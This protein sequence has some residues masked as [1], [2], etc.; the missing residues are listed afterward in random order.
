MEV[1]GIDNTRKTKPIQMIEERRGN[2]VD[3]LLT[4]PTLT[5]RQFLQ[6]EMRPWE[7]MESSTSLSIV[8][9]YT[10]CW[11]LPFRY[12]I[13][14]MPQGA[15]Q[16]RESPVHYHQDISTATACPYHPSA[17]S[18]LR[19]GGSTCLF[20]KTW[21]FNVC[22]CVYC[23]TLTHLFRLNTPPTPSPHPQATPTPSPVI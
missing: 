23:N 22:D 6:N 2:A 13:I 12:P 19:V 1:E 20:P 11:R 5:L 18:T 8:I 17:T 3:I 14:V 7:A 15:R 4:T 10:L 9:H 21:L 16:T